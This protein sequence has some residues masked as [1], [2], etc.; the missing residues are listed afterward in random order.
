M[1]KIQSFNMMNRICFCAGYSSAAIDNNVTHG[2]R[3]LINLNAVHRSKTP[4]LSINY[5]REGYMFYTSLC[6]NELTIS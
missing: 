2:P 1:E 6:Y 3:P 5:Y 4:Y